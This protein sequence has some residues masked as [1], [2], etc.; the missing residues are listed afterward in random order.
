M[1]PSLRPSLVVA[2]LYLNILPGSWI[3]DDINWKA[4]YDS[5]W[6]YKETQPRSFR[7]QP[8]IEHLNKRW[9]HT[10]SIQKQSLH[11]KN[12]MLNIINDVLFHINQYN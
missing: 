11:Q 4:K 3:G 1:S 9:Q 7:L 10:F 2:S 12:L 5:S 8:S 6:I